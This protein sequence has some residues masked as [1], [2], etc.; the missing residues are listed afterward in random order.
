M[1]QASLIWGSWLGQAR[2]PLHLG[3]EFV[4]EIGI[5]RGGRDG[6]AAWP[7]GVEHRR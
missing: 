2:A 4:G 5:E 1:A 7:D 3:I 6:A